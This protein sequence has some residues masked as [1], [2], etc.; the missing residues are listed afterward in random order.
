MYVFDTISQQSSQV[1]K[2]DVNHPVLDGVHKLRLDMVVLVL[3][4]LLCELVL[5]LVNLVMVLILQ[6]YLQ[7]FSYLDFLLLLED[8]GQKLGRLSISLEVLFHFYL[9]L[10]CHLLYQV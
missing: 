6:R 3:H 1:I 4:Y 2:V 9:V 7:L 5:E 10:N 8:C